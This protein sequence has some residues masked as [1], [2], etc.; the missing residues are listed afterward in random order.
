M[1]I[2]RTF[3][4]KDYRILLQKG[5]HHHQH[6]LYQAFLEGHCHLEVN[7]MFLQHVLIP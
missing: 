1:T 4:L 5:I 2:I 6:H 7:L 3:L